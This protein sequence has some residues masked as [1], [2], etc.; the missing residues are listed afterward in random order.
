MRHATF[1]PAIMVLAA[2]GA[3]CG[4]ATAG[5]AQTGRGGPAAQESG[6]AEPRVATAELAGPPGSPI[7]GVITFT[8]RGG[9]VAVH[10]EVTGV[11]DAGEHGFHVHDVGDCSAADFSSAGGHFNPAAGPHAGPHDVPRHAGD[12]GNLTVGAD[13]TGTLDLTTGLLTVADGPDS[14]VGRSVILHAAR[15]D[16]STQPTGNSGARIACGVVRSAGRNP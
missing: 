5:G 12:L 16:M 9:S 13:G 14:V 15:D 10:A 2:V 1:V 6:A 8:E 3:G 4:S 11:P 7:R